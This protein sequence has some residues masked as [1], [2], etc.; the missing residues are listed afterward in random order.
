MITAQMQGSVPLQT[1]PLLTLSQARPE[2]H[3]LVG[4]HAW[5]PAEQVAPG[6]QVP[7][8]APLGT[9]QRIPWQQSAPEVQAPFCGWHSEGGLHRPPVQMPEQHCE[10]K[11]QDVSLALQVG[12]ASGVPVPPS[13]PPP[14]PEVGCWQ[15]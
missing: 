7:V 2:Q 1:A 13:V 11:L 15:A 4:E 6:W 3:G 12:P 14:P 10:G 9:S 5:P 8:V